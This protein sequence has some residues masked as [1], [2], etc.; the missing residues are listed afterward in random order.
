M[1]RIYV[2]NVLIHNDEYEELKVGTP[3][4]EVELNQIGQASFYIY[5][6]HPYYNKFVS[7][8]DPTRFK[9]M[10]SIVE[11]Y[12]KDELLFRGRILENKDMFY[13]EKQVICE[14]ELAF[15]I[16]SQLRPY[17]KT[18]TP[19]E[20]LQFYIDSHNTQM[21]DYPEKQFILG[22]VTVDDSEE[23]DENQETRSSDS[24]VS[25]WEEISKLLESLGGY[26]IL[27]YNEDGKRQI[28]WLTEDDFPIGVQKIE[29]GKNLFDIQ[30]N[31]KGDEI[32]TALIPIGGEVTSTNTGDDTTQEEE[33][34]PVDD[35]VIEDEEVTDEEITEDETTE[36]V[37]IKLDITSYTNENKVAET[38]EGTVYKVAETEDDVIYKLNDCIYSKKGVE[39]YG[40]IFGVKE[41]ED[42]HED[43]NHLLEEGIK[44]LNETK[45]IVE[46]VEVK[47]LDVAKLASFKLGTKTKLT[48]KVHGFNDEEFPITKRTLTLTDPM[49]NTLTL[50]K[51]NRTFTETSAAVNKTTIEVGNVVER[52]DKVA[53]TANG[54][55]HAINENKQAIQELNSTIEQTSEEIITKVSEEY[56]TKDDANTL[57][58]SIGTEF[59]QTNESFEMK[60]TEINTSIEE[61]INNANDH[62]QEQ[63]KYIR[64]VDGNIVLGEVGNEITLK[65][66]N[67]RISFLQ[68]GVEVA[69]FSNNKLYVLD[70]EFINQLTLGKFAFIPRSNGS[71]DFKKVK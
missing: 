30:V 57:I 64:F 20:I 32:I 10:K 21:K 46:S 27:D 37:T 41:W 13:K 1:Y 60:F 16:D 54:L 59:A 36:E 71:L 18:G 31:T 12:E 50:T 5:P 62:Y 28:N 34:E 15:F 14:S 4:V 23:N 58:Q 3:E 69:Y 39:E 42:I 40:L 47:S 2:D 70:G 48:S 44:Y 52:V 8:N 38:E 17:S 45:K 33:V 9:K 11:I 68:N 63:V 25:V 24:I 67:D 61:I 26:L 35:E 19:Q 49:S 6:N 56:Y 29:Y 66:A 51:S 7:S 55:E 22:T 53:N 43:V 65:V